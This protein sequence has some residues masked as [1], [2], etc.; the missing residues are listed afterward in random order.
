[1]M[2]GMTAPLPA[3]AGGRPATQTVVLSPHLDDA[4]L[5]VGALIARRVSAGEPVEV[6]TA[7]T[8]GPAP[9]ALPRWMRRFG[10]YPARLAE[11][12]RALD[13]LGARRRRLGLPERVWREP[14]ARTV[15]AAFRTPARLESFT[16]LHPLVD[17]AGQLLDRP[18]ARLLAP[19][20]VGHHADHVE[21]ALAVL[22]AAWRRDAF[23]R[24]AFYEDY[25]ALGESVRRHH[26]VTRL[27]PFPVREAPGW[28]APSQGVVLLLTA[29]LGRGPGLDRYLPE[30]TGLGWSC[31]PEPVT[32]YERAKLAAV[33]EY[34]S[35]LP[36]LGGVRRVGALLGRAH[37]LRGGELIWYARPG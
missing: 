15:A 23:A 36:A 14:R 13:V 26:P 21:V 3:G 19:L 35:Q 7:F 8:A 32:G 10:D 1:M 11:D 31:E 20:G 30:F 27:R 2:A 33:A 9:Q 25:Y 22:L 5:S 24:V 18:G 29:L 28:A 12:E 34:R 6:W 37:R 4:V 16:Q 17:A